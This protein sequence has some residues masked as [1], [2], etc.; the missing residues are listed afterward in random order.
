MWKWKGRERRRSRTGLV[1]AEA[2][3]TGDAVADNAE[4]GGL[5]SR[6][7]PDLV[8]LDW[9]RYL[10]LYR[11]SRCGGKLCLNPPE[12]IFVDPGGRFLT[13]AA[14]NAG[15]SGRRKIETADWNGDGKLDL[16]VGAEDGFYYYW[17]R[18]YI[19]AIAR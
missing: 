3:A 9:R 11:H 8:M 6:R 12:R 2:E 16:I 13:M 14:D 19:E 1:A 10:A 4:G 15:R 5:E 17:E 7:V 18:S